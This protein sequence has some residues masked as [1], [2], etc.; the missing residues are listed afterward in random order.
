MG[1]E[2]EPE[3]ARKDNAPEQAIGMS[4]RAEVQLIHN[5]SPISRQAEVSSLLDAKRRSA[6]TR[7]SLTRRIFL[8]TTN[9]LLK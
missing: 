8:Q 4:W 9:V 3:V 7:S 1:L 5:A 6:D 2:E